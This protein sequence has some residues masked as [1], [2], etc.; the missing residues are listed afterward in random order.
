M[1]DKSLKAVEFDA[2]A[3]RAE[4]R[5]VRPER[6]IY[7]EILEEMAGLLREKIAEGASVKALADALARQGVK[8]G[9]RSL[10]VFLDTGQIAGKEAGPN[11]SARARKPP[12]QPRI[13][14]RGAVAEL[15]S[16]GLSETGLR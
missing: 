1:A 4:I 13:R 7:Q 10:K 14:T 3:L 8:V 15:I 5:K 6:V 11:Q 2:D 9:E 16:R 12:E